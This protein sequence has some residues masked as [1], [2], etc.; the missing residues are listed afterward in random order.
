MLKGPANIEFNKWYTNRKTTDYSLNYRGMLQSWG[1]ATPLMA[2]NCSPVSM[3]YGVYLIFFLEHDR[4]A[5]ERM[6]K[7]LHAVLY[8][9]CGIVDAMKYV[10]EKEGQI[11][12][13]KYTK[14]T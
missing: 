10:I 8:R 1:N 2:F 7:H 12:N 6:N 9:H 5:P 3:R 13:E 14:Q 11:F 4:K